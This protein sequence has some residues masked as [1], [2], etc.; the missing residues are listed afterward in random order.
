MVH[1]P[2]RE[3]LH[4]NRVIVSECNLTW[5]RLVRNLARAANDLD[6]RAKIVG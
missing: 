4:G 6:G 3:M 2:L 5:L 1:P